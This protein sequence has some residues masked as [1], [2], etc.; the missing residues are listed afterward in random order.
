MGIKG[1]MIPIVYNYLIFMKIID[2]FCK[3]PIDINP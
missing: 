2:L 3:L 1:Y